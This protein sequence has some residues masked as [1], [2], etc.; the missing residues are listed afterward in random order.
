M[1]RNCNSRASQP[2]PRSSVSE[3][4]PIPW[5]A[6]PTWR[7][8]GGTLYLG[9]GGL[10]LNNATGLLTQNI[11]LAAGTFGVTSDL[12]TAFNLQLTGN[13]T[14]GITVQTADAAGNAHN[15]TFSGNIS[16]SGALTKTGTGVLTFTGF[17]SYTGAT[18]VNTGTLA[19]I[20]ATSGVA[21][22]VA[23]DLLIASSTGSVAVVTMSNGST[24]N[25]SRVDIGGNQANTTGGV[26]TLNQ[27]DGTLN[28]G[29]WMTVGGVGTGTFNLLGGV[30]NANTSGGTTQAHFEVGVFGA[31]TGVMNQSSSTA[32]NLFY[33]ANIQMGGFPGQNDAAGVDSGNGTYNQNGGSVTFYSDNGFSIGGS[34][35][36]ALGEGLSRSGTY[37]YNLNGGTLTVP[38]ITQHSGTGI[39]N[40]NGG[41]LVAAGGT[42]SLIHDLTAAVVQV[43]GGTISANGQTAAISQSLSHDA[44]GPALDGGLTFTSGTLTLSGTNTYTG[45]TYVDDGTLIAVA[46]TALP[47]GGNLTVGD[48]AAAFFPAAVVPAPQLQAPAAVPEPATIATL[49]LGLICGGIWFRRRES[50][51]VRRI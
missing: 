14:S 42:A 27:Y 29:L 11:Y 36:L 44:S 9:S 30:A 46:S 35:Q 51:S 26:G 17:N 45:T 40:F 41:M 13:A 22:N 19:V 2:T 38:E 5:A 49:C 24:L 8:Y 34:G 20:G 28:S 18:V 37:T 50:S 47:D 33:N 43:G 48:G 12:T 10:V 23:N 16:G 4:P 7:L 31:A 25:A 21:T 6:P 15:I 3:R 39:L 1:L 32:L